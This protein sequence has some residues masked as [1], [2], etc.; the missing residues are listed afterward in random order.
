MPSTERLLR[1]GIDQTSIFPIISI[2]QDGHAG[3]NRTRPSLQT[4]TSKKRTILYCPREHR[5]F[6]SVPFNSGNSFQKQ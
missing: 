3:M 4:T 5:Y 2:Y 6:A 1:Q